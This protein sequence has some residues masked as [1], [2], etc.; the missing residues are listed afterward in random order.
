MAAHIQAQVN[1]WD[2]VILSVREIIIGHPCSM[3]YAYVQALKYAVSLLEFMMSSH[4]ICCPF[5][6]E[7][8]LE[9]C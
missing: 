6:I 5:S 8:T 2:L 4:K 7:N 9:K 1:D 3:K